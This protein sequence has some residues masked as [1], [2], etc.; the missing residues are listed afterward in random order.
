MHKVDSFESFALRRLMNKV[1]SKAFITGVL[2]WA[3]ILYILYVSINTAHNTQKDGE[4]TFSIAQN[5]MNYWL[6]RE[7]NIEILATKNIELSVG[8]PVFLKTSYQQLRKVGFV[9]QRLEYNSGQNAKILWY[10]QHS[11]P[12]NYDFIV[13]E[14]ATGISDQINLL[15]PS[16]TRNEILNQLVTQL[17]EHG[18]ELKASFVSILE[19]SLQESLPAINLALGE[20]LEKHKDK[21]EAITARYEKIIMQDHL[22]NLV[23]EEFFPIVKQHIEPVAS[24]LGLELWEQASIWR[25]GSSAIIDRTGLARRS[26]V[27]R[28]WNRFYNRTAEPIII[29][30]TDDFMAALKNILNDISANQPFREAIQEVAAEMFQDQELRQLINQILY[31]T[32]IDNPELRK[33][34][35]ENW[36][37]DEAQQAFALAKKHLEPVIKNIGV[38]LFGTSDQGIS[39]NFARFIRSQVLG[40]DKRWLVAKPSRNKDQTPKFMPSTDYIPYPILYLETKE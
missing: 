3:L 29:S 6:K 33:V 35:Q 11:D 2:F 38:T 15:I 10:D 40:K 32:L 23:S 12:Y 25:F 19:K 31:E 5:L 39:P 1:L 21:I 16:S 27:Q 30:Y 9:R 20:S 14:S 18:D 26:R 28:E 36:Q 8:D 13:Y 22:N 4:E 37:S 17:D 7:K 24:E 34:W